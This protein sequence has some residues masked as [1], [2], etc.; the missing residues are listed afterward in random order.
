MESWFNNV[1][2]DS[3]KDVMKHFFHD[4]RWA[5]SFHWHLRYGPGHIFGPPGS[6]YFRSNR[7]IPC[8]V[9]E[10]SFRAEK[11]LIRHLGIFHTGASFTRTPNSKFCYK[12]DLSRI[13]CTKYKD[14][15]DILLP[16][17]TRTK[18]STK[19]KLKSTQPKPVQPEFDKPKSKRMYKSKET[20]KNPKP[21]DALK[22][23]RVPKPTKDVKRRRS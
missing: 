22:A 20:L 9:C 15:V 19:S 10:V 14:T 1:K 12:V 8:H 16:N 23:R 2:C 18:R 3:H 4:D 7:G 5:P 21:K 6:R 11:D 17:K 13:S